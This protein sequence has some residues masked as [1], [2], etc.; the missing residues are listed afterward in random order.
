MKVFKK[1]SA[2]AV[3]IMFW[4]SFFIIHSITDVQQFQKHHKEAMILLMMFRSDMKSH[5]STMMGF[6]LLQLKLITYMRDVYMFSFGLCA[7]YEFLMISHQFSKIK[8][9]KLLLHHNSRWNL[10][11]IFALIGTFFASNT[12]SE[13]E[14]NM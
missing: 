13:A 5:T 1:H 11:A 9:R 4:I 10:K 8:P 3:K 14:K 7:A 12:A 2:L 6:K